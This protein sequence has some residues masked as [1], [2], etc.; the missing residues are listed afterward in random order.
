MYNCCFVK[1]I[2]DLNNIRLDHDTLENMIGA[3]YGENITECYR[4][5]VTSSKIIRKG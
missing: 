2:T 1:T 3:R 5:I 4:N